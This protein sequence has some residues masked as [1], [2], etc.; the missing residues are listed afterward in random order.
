MAFVSYNVAVA[1]LIMMQFINNCENT[2]KNFH[3]KAVRRISGRRK[4]PV[5]LLELFPDDYQTP[6]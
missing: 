1:L 3:N 5:Q 6:E 2:Q 4:T